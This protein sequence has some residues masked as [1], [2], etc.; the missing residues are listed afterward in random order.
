MLS[1]RKWNRQLGIKMCVANPKFEIFQWNQIVTN[2]IP[3][4]NSSM[5]SVDNSRSF[6]W[7]CDVNENKFV[8]II[9]YH[10][11]QSLKDL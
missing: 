3:L 1:S 4:Q 5:V 10:E 9:V 8:K 6:A 7:T 2:E 11:S